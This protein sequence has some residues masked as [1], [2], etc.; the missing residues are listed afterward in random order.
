M[1]LNLFKKKKCDDLENHDSFLSGLIVGRN[2]LTKIN[3]AHPPWPGK[4][5]RIIDGT[6]RVQLYKL[7]TIAFVKSEYIEKFDA[8]NERKCKKYI[9]DNWN[10]KKEDYESAV[11][12]CWRVENSHNRYNDYSRYSQRN[13]RRDRVKYK[14]Y[15]E[16]SEIDSEDTD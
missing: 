7:L 8:D 4:I 2:V 5:L 3:A 11:R 6:Y 9:I 1:P 14:W 10:E 12:K 13:F 16:D 15:K